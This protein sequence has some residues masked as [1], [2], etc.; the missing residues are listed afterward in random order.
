MRFVE[1]R[2]LHK[3]GEIVPNR[4]KLSHY[5][6]MEIIIDTKTIRIF[7]GLHWPLLDWKDPIIRAMRKCMLFDPFVVPDST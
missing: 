2:I 5:A 1:H 7:D 6:D 4:T 3:T